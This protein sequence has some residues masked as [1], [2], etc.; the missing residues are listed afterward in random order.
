M[1]ALRLRCGITSSTLFVPG[2][3]LSF[4]K[5]I[6]VLFIDEEYT[7]L[8]SLGLMAERRGLT[9]KKR[10]KRG[11]ICNLKRSVLFASN[12]V[13]SAAPSPARESAHGLPEEP[14][15]PHQWPP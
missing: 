6:E 4:E 8:G 12:A 1:N 15:A 9:R 2:T 10:Q 5:P 7:F 14:A 3:G 11:K 13:C